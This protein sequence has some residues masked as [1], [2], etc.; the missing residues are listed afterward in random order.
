MRGRQLQLKHRSKAASRRTKVGGLALLYTGSGEQTFSRVG[1]KA[2]VDLS[3]GDGAVNFHVSLPSGN[4][5]LCDIVAF[6]NV[7][8][9]APGQFV[10]PVDTL[11]AVAG[12]QA[13]LGHG[14]LQ[15]SGVSF[16]R[17]D[18]R[19]GDENGRV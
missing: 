17:F 7:F 1:V 18:V 2:N 12:N 14:A 9:N 3:G 13:S 8:E 19:P 4:E 11:A 16:I 15:I 10:A 5:V 6:K